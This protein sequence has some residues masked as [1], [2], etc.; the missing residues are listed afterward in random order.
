V[1]EEE[2]SKNGLMVVREKGGRK[3]E[4]HVDGWQMETGGLGV[5]MGAETEAKRTQ[6]IT[7]WPWLGC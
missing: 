5:G 1:V 7:S 3:R 2:K 6:A 4:A